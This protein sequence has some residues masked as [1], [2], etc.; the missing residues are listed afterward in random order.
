MNTY[1]L[2]INYRTNSGCNAKTL[3]Q[4]AE[5]SEQALELAHARVRR[6]R[7]VIK[8]DGGDCTQIAAADETAIRKD[9]ESTL[10]IFRRA[11]IDG[12]DRASRKAFAVPHGWQDQDLPRLFRAVDEQAE[13]LAERFEIKLVEKN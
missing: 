9:R 2:C 4:R 7:G 10:D 11:V 1:L 5:N 6:M 8:I 3:R 13:V 12:L